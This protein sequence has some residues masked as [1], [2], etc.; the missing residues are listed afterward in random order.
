MYHLFLVVGNTE[1]VNC[2]Y[3]SVFTIQ[4]FT[5]FILYT[6]ELWKLQPSSSLITQNSTKYFDSGAF[7]L[8][9]YS[10]LCKFVHVA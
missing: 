4:V 9:S 5:C 2:H 8:S 7:L 6:D 10:F 1:Q 3:W